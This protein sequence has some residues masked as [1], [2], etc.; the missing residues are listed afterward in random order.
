MKIGTRKD[1]FE[2]GKQYKLDPRKIIDLRFSKQT[3]SETVFSGGKHLDI[4][5]FLRDLL[6]EQFLEGEHFEESTLFVKSTLR[7]AL[8]EC[9]AL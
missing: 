9:R 2:E 1:T 5:N 6:G 7:R 8:L 3:C 4:V